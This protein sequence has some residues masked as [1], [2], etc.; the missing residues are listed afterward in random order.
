MNAE[1]PEA[2]L[3]TQRTL[4]IHH[5]GRSYVHPLPSINRSHV[6]YFTD[7][8]PSSLPSLSRTKCSTTPY[9]RKVNTFSLASTSY[10]HSST[11]LDSERPGNSYPKDSRPCDSGN[12]VRRCRGWRF[13]VSTVTLSFRAEAAH[14]LGSPTPRRR[15]KQS[16]GRHNSFRDTF[17]NIMEDDLLSMGLPCSSGGR[18]ERSRGRAL[19][20]V[21][22]VSSD[23]N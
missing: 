22:R 5:S 1:E 12:V 19:L 9:R 14:H 16:S 6:L 17:S 3:S 23:E 21:P 20:P 13:P 4:N 8:S 18:P 7:P 15:K 11:D 2:G 10:P